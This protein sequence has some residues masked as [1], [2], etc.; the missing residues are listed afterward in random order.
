M[1]K[2]L[3]IILTI[4]LTCSM[5]TACGK[6]PDKESAKEPEKETEEQ[7]ENLLAEK[8]LEDILAAI[9]EEKSPEFPLL[10]TNV[11]LADENAVKAFTGLS[12]EDAEKVKEVL[13]SESAMGSQAY[14]LVLLRLKDAKDAEAIAAS[15][16]KGIDPR[17]WICVEADDLRVCASGDVVMLV[18]ISSEFADVLTAEQLTDA[19]A[20]VAG[21]SL[22]VELN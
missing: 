14:S 20:S 6:Q 18:M 15:M 7:P 11:D 8:N 9:Y 16:K 5:L 12:K 22:S 4:I 1:K 19:F 21:G 13:A 10:S 17:K 3:S 2:Y